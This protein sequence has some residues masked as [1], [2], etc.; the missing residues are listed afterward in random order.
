MWAW[1]HAS[2]IRTTSSS[3]GFNHFQGIDSNGIRLEY[4]LGNLVPFETSN[5]SFQPDFV[6]TCATGSPIAVG[7]TLVLFTN[8]KTGKKPPK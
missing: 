5:I 6:S 2:D 3:S 4:M 8:E 7:W 1:S